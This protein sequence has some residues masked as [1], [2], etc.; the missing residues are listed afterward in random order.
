MSA[1]KI[2]GEWKKGVFKPIYWLEGEES[3]FIDQVVSHAEHKILNEAEAGFN[4]TI[5]YGKDADW[6]S[7][8]NACMRYPCLQKDRWCC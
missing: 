6:A 5:F 4:L 1:E 8:V 7:V 2:I 3:F